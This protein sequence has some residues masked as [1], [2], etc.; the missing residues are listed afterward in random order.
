MALLVAVSACC[1]S[2]GASDSHPRLSPSAAARP[3]SEVAPPLARRGSDVDIIHGTRVEDPYRW[4][5]DGRS[6]E[7][8]KWTMMYDAY[9]RVVLGS[10]P[11][12]A[13]LNERLAELS[14]VEKVTP[15]ERYGDRF[16]FWR[17]HKD[18]EMPVYYWRQGAQG[19]EAAL[20]APNAM[21]DGRDAVGQRRAGRRPPA[22]GQER[23]PQGWRDGRQAYRGMDRPVR[24]PLRSSRNAPMSGYGCRGF[25]SPCSSRRVRASAVT[26]GWASARARRQTSRA[27]AGLAD[28]RAVKVASDV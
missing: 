19:K 26:W 28:V 23:G 7:V 11:D 15:P 4:L 21:G 6:L 17:S 18:M 16:F 1:P 27:A 24:V 10:L 14:Y 25:D 13:W 22:R 12:R 8:R 20:L 5:E 9:T 2:Q 3:A